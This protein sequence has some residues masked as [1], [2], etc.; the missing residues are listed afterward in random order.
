[1]FGTKKLLA[2]LMCLLLLCA[3]CLPALA[4]EVQSVKY[5]EY[6]WDGKKLTSEEKTCTATKLTGGETKLRTGWYVA[7]G[8][9]SFNYR[10]NVEGAST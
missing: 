3:L 1:M 6:K 10:P 2:A 9:F 5:I 4:E 7:K 8:E